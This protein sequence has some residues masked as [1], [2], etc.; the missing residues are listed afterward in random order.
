MA[1]PRAARAA[2]NVAVYRIAGLQWQLTNK[3]WCTERLAARLKVIAR[4]VLSTVGDLRNHAV[5]FVGAQQRGVQAVP[6]NEVKFHLCPA[7]VMQGRR[8]AGLD[9]GAGIAG[10]LFAQVE[11]AHDTHKFIEGDVLQGRAI[12]G[13]QVAVVG[14]AQ[15]RSRAVADVEPKVLECGGPQSLRDDLVRLGA[16]F[17]C[18]WGAATAGVQQCGARVDGVA[19]DLAQLQ[20]KQIH[21]NLF[22]LLV[23]APQ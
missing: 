20:G 8:D 23:Q 15:T 12:G 19:C 7:V 6:V 16:F 9:L 21:G 5:Q 22:G 14:E 11:F 13:C 1:T 4:P 10:N 18:P 2:R 3:K 17:D